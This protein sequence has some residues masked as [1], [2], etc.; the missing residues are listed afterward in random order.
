MEKK[1]HAM[2]KLKEKGKE[3]KIVKNQMKIKM[4]K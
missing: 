1:I 3:I 4:P 2:E